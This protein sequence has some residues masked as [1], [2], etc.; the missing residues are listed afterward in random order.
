MQ[1]LGW[2][3]VFVA[4]NE[5]TGKVQMGNEGRERKEGRWKVIGW[6][7]F[8]LAAICVS[9]LLVYNFNIKYG[10]DPKNIKNIHIV[11]G[12]PFVWI[13]WWCVSIDDWMKREAWK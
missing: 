13:T 10:T 8:A 12:G 11:I 9:L 3:G 6:M 5:R 7:F 4:R 1:R 2:N